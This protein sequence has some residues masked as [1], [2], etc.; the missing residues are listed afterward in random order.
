MFLPHLGVWASTVSEY[1][2]V[3][4]V[5]S[6]YPGAGR[7]LGYAS[8]DEGLTWQRVIDSDL[9]VPDRVLQ[10]VPKHMHHLE[11]FEWFD[12]SAAA[13]KIGVVAVLG[14][15][16]NQGQV[17]AR[18]RGAT[19]PDLASDSY[20]SVARWKVVGVDQLTDLFPLS[21]SGTPSGG[22]VFWTAPTEPR[23]AWRA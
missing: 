13:W 7:S 8:I 9:D 22:P 1:V 21:S 18:A 4:L 5:S 10:P 11:P 12:E 16:P 20:A 15:T 19:L 17:I 3:G 23:A 2:D 6:V 14:D